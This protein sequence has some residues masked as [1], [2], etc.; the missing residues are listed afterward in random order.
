MFWFVK[1][2]KELFCGIKNVSKKKNHYF[3]ENSRLCQIYVPKI[4][5]PAIERTKKN[6]V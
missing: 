5:P 3:L 2:K 4:A 6:V 1:R